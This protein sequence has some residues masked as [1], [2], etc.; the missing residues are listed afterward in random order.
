MKC[1]LSIVN[2]QFRIKLDL[3]HRW[4]YT[5]DAK[6]V[7]NMEFLEWQGCH[8]AHCAPEGDPHVTAQSLLQGLYRH[9]T[10]ETL[11]PICRTDMGKPYLQ[12]CP[13]HISVSH[14]D[15]RV[16]CCMSRVNVGMDAEQTDRQAKP[17]Y[18]SA[19]ERERLA[20]GT[21][22]QRDFLRLWVLKESYAKLTGKGV[23]SYLKQT[24]FSPDDPRV[25]E[26]AG[27][28]VAVLTQKDED[29]AF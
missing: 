18:L 13:W 5:D 23:G 1:Q 10:G 29:H 7:R 3:W 2:C 20:A 16:F 25:T 21:D 14:T 17:A 27:C 15:R 12:N 4:V 11:P 22:P 8:M 19:S 28:F 24:D 26:I 6:G 9:V